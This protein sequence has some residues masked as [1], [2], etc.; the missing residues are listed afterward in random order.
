MVGGRG[1]VTQEKLNL[2]VM[3]LLP[4]PPPSSLQKPQYLFSWVMRAGVVLRGGGSGGALGSKFLRKL[5][6]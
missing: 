6:S 2:R 4:S 3:P 1:M 5:L